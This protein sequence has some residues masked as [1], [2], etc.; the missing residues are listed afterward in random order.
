VIGQA[1]EM[2]RRSNKEERREGNKGTKGIKE[3]RKEM[4]FPFFIQY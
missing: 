4:I 2:D 1:N 3:R